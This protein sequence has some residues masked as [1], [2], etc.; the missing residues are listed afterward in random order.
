[1]TSLSSFSYFGSNFGGLEEAE[2]VTVMTNLR[3]FCLNFDIFG[4]A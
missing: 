2:T 1:M 3:S 4:A